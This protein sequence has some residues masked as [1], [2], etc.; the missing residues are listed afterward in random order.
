MKLY[1]YTSQE[2]TLEDLSVL[3]TLG[4]QGWRI[5]AIEEKQGRRFAILE[6][7]LSK[8]KS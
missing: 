1:E 4:V 5:I 3:T 8:T 6:R 7:E 2:F